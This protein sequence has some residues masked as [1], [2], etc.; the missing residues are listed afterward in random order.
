MLNHYLSQKLKLI[1]RDKFNYLI[2]ILFWLLITR[3][4]QSLKFNLIFLPLQ[5]RKLQELL[6]KSLG[7]EFQLNSAADGMYLEED[8][9]VSASVLKTELL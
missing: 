7:W 1:G 6:E 9:E 5:T 8:D 4:I 2:N 3:K